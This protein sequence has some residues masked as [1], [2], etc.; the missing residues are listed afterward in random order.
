MPRSQNALAL[1]NAGFLFQF[2][3]NS[4]TIK[5]ARITYGNISPNFIHAIKTENALI[6][7][8]LYTDQTL[9]LALN[10]LF[11]EITP[12]ERPPEASADFRRMLAVTLFYKVSFC[13]HYKCETQINVVD[14][15]INFII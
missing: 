10:T 13:T 8:E 9:K 6:G 15:T 7:K 11:N 2:N 1:V 3:Q 12:D 4:N 5:K 14:I